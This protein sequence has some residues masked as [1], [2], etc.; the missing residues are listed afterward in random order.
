MSIAIEIISCSKHIQKELYLHSEGLA[1][2]AA[3]A[4]D[5]TESGSLK[6]CQI[7][8]VELIDF[9]DAV[10]MYFAMQP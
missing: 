4:N 7:K 8:A 3:E 5:G 2:L 10:L 1:I 9:C 6:R